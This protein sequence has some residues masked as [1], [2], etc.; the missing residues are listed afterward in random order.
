MTAKQEEQLFKL[1]TDILW[2]LKKMKRDKVV[3]AKN[4]R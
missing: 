1:L 3:R 4:F 2:T